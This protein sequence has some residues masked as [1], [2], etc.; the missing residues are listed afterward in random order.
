MKSHRMLAQSSHGRLEVG[1]VRETDEEGDVKSLTQKELFDFLLDVALVRP[2]FIWGAPGIGK[3]SIVNEF[4]RRLGLPCVSLL[5]SQLAPEDL[6]GVPQIVNG[7]SRFCPPMTIARE[8]PYCLFLDELNACTHEVQ[9]AFYSLILERRIGEYVL[10]PDSVVIGAGNRAQDKAIVRPMPSALVNRM[11]HVELRVDPDDWLEWARA[12]DIDHRIVA[13]ISERPDHLW[14]KPKND[15]PFST[16]RSWHMLSDALKSLGPRPTK[17]ALNAVVCGCL[18]PDHASHFLAFLRQQEN[19]LTIEQIIKGQAK[20]P[21]DADDRPLLIYLAECFRSQL[22]KELPPD[23]RLATGA[24]KHFIQRAKV[25]LRELV[26]IST[27]VARLVLVENGDGAKL[28]AWFL[29]EVARDLPK[30]VP[31]T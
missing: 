31:S 25:L 28:P 30:V 4:A 14:S 26:A 2:V 21:R 13:Y 7:K 9:K 20:W 19:E 8:G 15:E 10:H 24:Q 18:S 6:I 1:R 27:E 29:G 3:S 22:L 11:V 23:K 16:P 5:G 12:H 17:A